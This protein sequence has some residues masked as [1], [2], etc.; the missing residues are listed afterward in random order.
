M[1]YDIILKNRRIGGRKMAVDKEIE[2]YP[3]IKEWLEQLGYTVRSEVRG[4]DIVAMRN[5][6][7]SQPIIVEMKKSFNLA[8]LYQAVERLELTPYVYV[9]IETPE[10]AS[11]TIQKNHRSM[12]QLCRRLQI[13]LLTV[14]FRANG[15]SIVQVVMDPIVHGE[16]VVPSSKKSKRVARQQV[17]LLKEFAARSGDHNIG[18]STRQKLVTAYREQALLCAYWLNKLGPLEPKKL[19][20][21]PGMLPAKIQPLLHNNVYGWFERVNRGIYQVNEEGK[22]ALVEYSKLVEQIIP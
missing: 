14:R 2:L 1:G 18:G 17:A 21:Q 16:S 20:T 6:S 9:A 15:T 10:H 4:C 7:D 22:K 3:P 11:K 19:R 13:G 8:L 12:E 5:A